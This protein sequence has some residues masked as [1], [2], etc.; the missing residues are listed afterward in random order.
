MGM[1]ASFRFI[2]LSNYVCVIIMMIEVCIMLDDIVHGWV[3]D[4]SIYGDQNAYVRYML[5]CYVSYYIH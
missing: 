3:H 4:V 2:L 5:S 1:H